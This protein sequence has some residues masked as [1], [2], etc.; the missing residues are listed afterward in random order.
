[1]HVLG[2]VGDLC[3]RLWVRTTVVALCRKELYG[4]NNDLLWPKE[5]RRDGEEKREGSRTTTGQ[6][7]NTVSVGWR[8]PRAKRSQRVPKGN[9]E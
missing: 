6:C 1:V 4:L 5:K 2:D 3:V 8:E 7:R 9:V